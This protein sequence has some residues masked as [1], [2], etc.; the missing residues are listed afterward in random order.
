[1][2][3]FT[4]SPT[5]TPSPS[6][7]A[8]TWVAISGTVSAIITATGVLIAGGFAYFKF[9]K[10]RTF[11]PRCS[12]EI[13]PQLKEIGESRALQISV[14]VRNEGLV[15]LL[16]PSDIP[17]RLFVGQADSAMWEQACKRGRRVVWE[18]SSIPKG[19]YNLA[20][21]EGNSL[22]LPITKDKQDPKDNQD[23]PWWR[24]LSRHWLLRHLRGDKLEPGEQWVRSILVP[25]SP[26]GVAYLLR[27]RVSACRHLAVRHVI[28][29]RRRCCKKKSTALTWLRDVYLLPTGSDDNGHATIQAARVTL[30]R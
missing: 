15:A 25:V 3:V 24:R 16:F 7:M 9:I 13:E 8:P 5:P 14:T 4:S 18:R 1:M 22:E 26:D 12:I 19:R 30:S 6:P 21:P 17:Q 11:R 29:H 28:W 2:V 27:A 20:V 23:L 10:G